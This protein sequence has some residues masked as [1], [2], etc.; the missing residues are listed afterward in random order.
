VTPARVLA[1]LALLL[2][3]T[4]LGAL[5]AWSPLSSVAGEERA[6][7]LSRVAADPGHYAGR[8]V[9]VAGELVD[10]G[11]FSLADGD[12]AVVVGDG[13]GRRVLALLGPRARPPAR[14]AEHM[15]LLISGVVRDVQPAAR[16]G[17]R[18][19]LAPRNLLRRARAQALIRASRVEALQQRSEPR[20]VAPAIDRTTVRMLIRRPRRFDDGLVAVSG[21]AHRI[22]PRGFILVGDRRSIFVAARP[23][24][25]HTLRAGERVRVR[26]EL[27]RISRFRADAIAAALA[28]TAERGGARPR[29]V[30][31][32]RTPSKPSRPFLVLRELR[33]D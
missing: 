25:S 16:T 12:T 6:V 11:Y 15:R 19:D 9:R 20:P 29:G 32:A 24:E 27:E 26:G 3:A 14:P 7:T 17:E 30:R 2:C 23:G 31:L 10:T 13:A 8:E 1:P 28:A 21:H 5:L 33:G 22:G 4:A 18:L